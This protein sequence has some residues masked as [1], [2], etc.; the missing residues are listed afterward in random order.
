MLYSEKTPV[1]T[2]TVE[3]DNDVVPLLAWF[4][5]AR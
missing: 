2:D 4:G 5:T 3:S 1:S